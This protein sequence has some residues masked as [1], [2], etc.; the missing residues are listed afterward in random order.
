MKINIFKLNVVRQKIPLSIKLYKSP[1]NV[2]D[3]LKV[4]K[5]ADLCKHRQAVKTMQCE[6]KYFKMYLHSFWVRK[7]CWQTL[8]FNTSENG[9][10]Q[11]KSFCPLVAAKQKKNSFLTLTLSWGYQHGFSAEAR[12]FLDNKTPI[13]VYVTNKLECGI[14]LHTK[15]KKEHSWVP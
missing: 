2:L 3:C 7:K 6:K 9:R 4:M 11:P 10:Q 13:Y 12:S 14:R 8:N 15:V 1:L 5:L